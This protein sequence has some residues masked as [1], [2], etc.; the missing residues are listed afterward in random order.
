[1]VGLLVL[2]EIT[3][4]AAQVAPLGHVNRTEGIAGQAE[5]AEAELDHVKGRWKHPAYPLRDRFVAA[6]SQDSDNLA[7]GRFDRCAART[8]TVPATVAQV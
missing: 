5:K 4:L 3:M 7:C 1:M 8:N 2:E 6:V